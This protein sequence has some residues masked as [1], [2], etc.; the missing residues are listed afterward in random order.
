MAFKTKDGQAFTNK[1]AARSHEA[2]LGESRPRPT[3]AT[4]Q[5]PDMDDLVT[6][7]HCGA[8]FSPSEVSEAQNAAPPLQS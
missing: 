6:C 8:Q 4:H 3:P 7:P 5:E 1:P 2:H